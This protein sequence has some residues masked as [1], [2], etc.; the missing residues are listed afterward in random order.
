[1]IPTMQF[2]LCH[3]DEGSKVLRFHCN[4]TSNTNAIV[5]YRSVGCGVTTDGHETIGFE[6]VKGLARPFRRDAVLAAHKKEIYD[7]RGMRSSMALLLFQSHS[8]VGPEGCRS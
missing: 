2:Y 4:L 7:R 8:S 5:T 3:H 1:M 6:L